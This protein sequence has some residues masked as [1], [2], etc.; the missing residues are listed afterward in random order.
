MYAYDVNAITFMFI[1]IPDT[2]LVKCE[3]FKIISEIFF[4][5]KKTQ[6]CIDVMLK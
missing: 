5:Y 1:K 4:T 2:K 6:V 3:L